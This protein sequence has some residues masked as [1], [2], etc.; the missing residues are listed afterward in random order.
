VKAIRGAG[1]GWVLL[2]ALSEDQAA[3][4]HEYELAVDAIFDTHASCLR[5]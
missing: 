1:G 4:F 5:R 2:A 3:A